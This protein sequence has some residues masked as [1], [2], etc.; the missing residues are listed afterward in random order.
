M[1]LR[2]S[3][4]TPPGEPPEEPARAWFAAVQAQMGNLDDL[5]TKAKANLVTAINEASKTG[6]GGH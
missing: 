2:P 5:T 6:S 3:A 4:A 1:W